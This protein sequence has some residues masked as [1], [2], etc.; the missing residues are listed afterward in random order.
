LLAL[1][2]NFIQL[3][4]EHWVISDLPGKA[5]H[6]RTV[7]IPGWVK[8]AI[9]EWKNAGGIADGPL[10]RSINKTG[11]VWGNRHDTESTMGDCS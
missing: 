9:D 6:I 7:P 5:G 10:F 2:I 4:E 8:A 11:R 3:R 1:R